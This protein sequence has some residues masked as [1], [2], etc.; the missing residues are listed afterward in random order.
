[1][2]SSQPPRPSCSP[3]RSP[4]RAPT[5]THR[6][7]ALE[8]VPAIVGPAPWWRFAVGL[9]AAR[10]VVDHRHDGLHRH[11]VVLGL[12]SWDLVDPDRTDRQFRGLVGAPEGRSSSSCSPMRVRSARRVGADASSRPASSASACRWPSSSDGSSRS[13]CS[14]TSS[15]GR[16][17]SSA[18]CWPRRTPRGKAVVFNP[19]VPVRIRQT[20]NIESGLNDGIALPIFIVSLKTARGDRSIPPGGR[21]HHRTG[22]AGGHRVAWS[23]SPWAGSAPS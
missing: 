11:R 12:K 8:Y 13:C 20:L 9:E 23:A 15:C 7:A 16:R 6:T 5:D 19:R 10:H 18:P 14:V 3:D 2:R 22:A 17:R 21:H 1:M 4:D